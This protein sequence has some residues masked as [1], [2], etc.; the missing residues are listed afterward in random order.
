MAESSTSGEPD[1]TTSDTSEEKGIFVPCASKSDMGPA[2]I[3]KEDQR[4]YSYRK[5]SVLSSLCSATK[6][7]WHILVERLDKSGRT[8]PNDSG[9]GT[10]FLGKFDVPNLRGHPHKVHGLFTAYHVLG[11]KAIR[12]IRSH[13]QHYRCTVSNR[14]MPLRERRPNLP[15]RITESTFC[16]TC[17]LLDVTFIEFDLQLVDKVYGEHK[18]DFL[19]VYTGWDGPKGLTEFDVLHHPQGGDQCHSHG[20]LEKHHGLH[21]FHS[22]S[23]DK[24]SSGAPV[25]CAD[26]GARECRVVAI[27]TAR[28]KSDS[29]NYNVAV[30]SEAV[31]GALIPAW[32]DARNSKGKGDLVSHHPSEDELLGQLKFKLEKLG[33]K[34]PDKI[35]PTRIP[36]YFTHPGLR[37]SGLKKKIPIHFVLTSHGW[38]W[39][40]VAPE[41]EEPNWASAKYNV[42]DRGSPHEGKA[43]DDES[44]EGQEC[45]SFAKLR[46]ITL[47]RNVEHLQQ[48]LEI[49]S[50][51]MKT[52]NQ[53]YPKSNP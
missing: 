33:L 3:P 31:F 4:C 11:E 44:T 49:V 24:G 50:L 40:A 46:S 52:N 39:S 5:I 16:F 32:K 27:H 29:R 22:V 43:V 41:D 38:Y 20:H 15:L 37:V 48:Q 10:C 17:P 28:S 51:G 8:V 1:H 53:G 30:S 18:S 47:G 21:L 42:F 2:G 19:H 34:P 35:I 26:A 9:P 14:G 25:L 23:T 7:V 12:R 6:A 36:V 13:D 45:F